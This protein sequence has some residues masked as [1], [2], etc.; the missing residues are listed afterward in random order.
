MSTWRAW[1]PAQAKCAAWVVSKEHRRRQCTR[2]PNGTGYCPVHRQRPDVVLD[3][4]QAC[5]CM[6]AFFGLIAGAS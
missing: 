2:Y 1:H 5:I 4:Q 6:A 3:A